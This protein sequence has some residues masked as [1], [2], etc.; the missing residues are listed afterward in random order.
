MNEEQNSNN[1]NNTSKNKLLLF[2]PRTGLPK[3]GKHN[4]L[5]M[6]VNQ[7]ET[8]K[9]APPEPKINVSR[10]P[11]SC[12]MR[13]IRDKTIHLELEESRYHISIEGTAG[14]ALGDV[15]RALSPTEPAGLMVLNIMAAC[16]AS[17]D[18]LFLGHKEEAFTVS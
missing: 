9:L 15:R 14:K 13:Q 6:K 7:T 12:E 16:K 1:K 3:K 4:C 10:P 11:G 17:R 2:N 5:G 8:G 18:S